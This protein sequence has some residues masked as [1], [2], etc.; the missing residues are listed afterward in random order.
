MP[1]RWGAIR[2][3]IVFF[4]TGF[5]G[6]WR[7][8]VHANRKSRFTRLFI[9]NNGF[10]QDLTRQFS[11]HFCGLFFWYIFQVVFWGKRSANALGW[12]VLCSR[13]RNGVLGDLNGWDG[14]YFVGEFACQY[15]S[16]IFSGNFSDARK[17]IFRIF[18]P[19]VNSFSFRDDWYIMLFKLRSQVTR[20]LPPRT[21]INKETCECA[22]AVK[23]GAWC[24]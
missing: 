9:E 12:P 17:N 18:L 22:G 13:R 15:F 7:S 10:N 5:P 19:G 23:S 24:K 21:K 16:N 14:F 8:D 1:G 2:V 3:P 20:S 11:G 4:R 6:F